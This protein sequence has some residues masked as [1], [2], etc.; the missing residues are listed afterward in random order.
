V[1]WK[2]LNKFQES[3]RRLLACYGIRVLFY[4][5]GRR[6]CEIWLSYCEQ[7]E[8]TQLKIQEAADDKR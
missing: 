7:G 6:R 1:V 8:E 4:T 2:E 5:F 3:I